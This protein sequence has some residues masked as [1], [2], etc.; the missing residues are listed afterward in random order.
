MAARRGVSKFQGQ[1]QQ[2]KWVGAPPPPPP[3]PPPLTNLKRLTP[4]QSSMSARLAGAGKLTEQERALF[5]NRCPRGYKKLDLLGKG[6]C[7][8][9]WLG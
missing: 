6:G 3:P 2:Q 8:V 5:G 9:V 1:Q 4:C 7:A